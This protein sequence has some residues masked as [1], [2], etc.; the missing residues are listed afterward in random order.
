[1]T[2]GVGSVGVEAN[3][4][5]NSNPNPGDATGI[6]TIVS[7]E[8][9]VVRPQV[10]YSISG[11]CLQGVPTQKGLYIFGGRKYVIK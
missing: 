11:R 7:K 3:T 8:Q 10:W 6:K 9:K 5:Q 1:M 4:V 2:V